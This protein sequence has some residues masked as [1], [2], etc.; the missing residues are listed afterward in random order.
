MTG[1]IR[2]I[3]RPSAD[4]SS[5]RGIILAVRPARAT[6]P[7]RL[8]LAGGT[9]DIWP[10]YLA[11]PPPV[12]TV[13]AALGLPAEAR[14]EPR[15]RGLRLAGA[16]EGREVSEEHAGRAAL[17]EALAR[18]ASRLPLLGQAVL[19]VEGAEALSLSTRAES[20]VGAGLGGSSALLV[21]ILG[22][23]RAA[24]GAPDDG[25]ALLRLAQ[26]VETAV[27]KT[28]TG[29]QDYHPPLRGGC[30][31]LEGGVEGV[32]ATRLPVDL[33]ALAARC[34]LV[35]TG[36]PHVSGLTNWG[37]V[38]A[39]FDGEAGTRAALEAIR[40]RAAE[41]ADALR[42]GD[43]DAALAA[44]V[45]EGSV[46]RRMAPGVTTPAI[47]ALDQAVRRAGALG[48][49]ICGAG[50]GGSVLVVLGPRSDAQAVD[51]AIDE[52]HLARLPL[53]LPE[54]GLR[55]EVGPP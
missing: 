24:V 43:L 34:R 9:L 7:V 32:R 40:V 30:L 28:P 2:A 11:L 53:V 21:A 36:A 46:R 50:G 14:V 52:A 6:A 29:Y 41:V 31:V 12:L 27:L 54:G 39:F 35:Y 19:A 44:A 37:V 55:V 4:L 5:A 16:V 17:A 10:V 13:N 45:E 18:G 20:P 15:S 25:E 49:K 51:R 38:R 22:A 42:G 48:T 33:A 23:L 1:T 3:V 8:D 47:E 26:G